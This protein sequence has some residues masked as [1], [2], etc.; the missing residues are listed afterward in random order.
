[1]GE[2][3][4][5]NEEERPKSLPPNLPWLLSV[6]GLLS[7]FCDQFTNHVM[8]SVLQAHGSAQEGERMS[9]KFKCFSI[10]SGQYHKGL[11]TC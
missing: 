10:N 8:S 5:M 1:M 4:R 9:L 6:Q 11:T 7:P 3:R 2:G